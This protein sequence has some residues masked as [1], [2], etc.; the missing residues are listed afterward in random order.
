MPE[1]D[2]ISA[3]LASLKEDEAKAL[4]KEKLDA[5]VPATDILGA[6]QDALAEVGKRFETGEYFISELMYA[7]EIMK[8]ITADL[9]PHLKGL[10]AA[11]GDARTIVFGTVRGD[12]HDIGKDVCILMLRGAGYQVVDLGVNVAPEKFAQAVGE[13]GAFMVGMSVFL[14]TCC[15]AIE[16]TVRALKAAGLRE[17]VSIMIGGAAASHF[18]AERT[19]CDGFGA[20]AVDAVTLAT[21]AVGK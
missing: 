15:K 19:G 1:L 21:E 18:V 13:H 6:C 20:T 10:P 7:G 3:A 14:T 16:E 8:D 17:G 9:E 2:A 5:G 12:I 11:E 4:V